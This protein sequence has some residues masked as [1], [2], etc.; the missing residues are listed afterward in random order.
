MP[1][2]IWSLRCGIKLS[3]N[4]RNMMTKNVETIEPSQTVFDAAKIMKEKAIGC[5][6]VV[7]KGNTIG[8]V[9]ERDIVR[10]VVAENSNAMM[11]KVDSVMSKPLVTIG[12]STSIRN[13]AATMTK[14]RIRRLPVVEN[15]KLVGIITATDLAKYLIHRRR[16]LGSIISIENTPRIAE[17]ASICQFFRQDPYVPPEQVWRICGACYWQMDEH[18]IHGVA[19][20]LKSLVSPVEG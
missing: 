16:A 4:V 8:I 12:P 18:C 17:G 6:V 2:R 14:N 11:V 3:Y 20:L 5:L 1:E 9:T 7:E 10:R 15:S 13:A 19:G